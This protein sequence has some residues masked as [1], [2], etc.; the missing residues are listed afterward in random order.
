[1]NKRRVLYGLATVPPLVLLSVCAYKALQRKRHSLP[2]NYDVYLSFRG[3]DTR[4]CFVDFLYTSLVA[5]GVHVFRDNDALP[6]G[7]EIGPE[8]LRAIRSC[9]IVIP[10]ISEQYAQSKWCLRELVEIMDCHKEHG[11]SVFPVFYKVELYDIR[12]GSGN[13]EE[14]LSKHMRVWPDEVAGWRKALTMVTGLKGWISQITANGNEAEL[15][16]IVVGRVLSELKTTG[17]E[18]LPL[19]PILM[20]NHHIRSWYHHHLEKRRLHSQVFL[21]F[22]RCD[23]RDSF[24]AYLHIKLV[25]A[26]I[27]VFY[28]D[29][30]SLLG[31]FI[32]EELMNTIEHSKISI[33]IISQNFTSSRWC[34]RELECMVKCNKT[35]GQKILPIFYKVNPWDMKHMSPCFEVDFRKHKENYPNE[36]EGWK[37]AF[38]EV[39][40]FKGWE[41][42]KIANG[43]ESELVKLVVGEVSRL[44]KNSQT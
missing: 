8:L 9:R 22:R 13:F 17:I 12:S 42:E 44:L 16:K 23:T 32:L 33:P 18:R 19:F 28:D 20:S 27:R 25:A 5:A 15:V 36:C 21:A 39:A 40:S 2:W 11:I 37:R 1:M 29:D 24:A 3:P 43:H 31:K 26:K 35:K 38:K 14:A 41:S 10:I 34:L 7:E 4:S 30:T 6:V